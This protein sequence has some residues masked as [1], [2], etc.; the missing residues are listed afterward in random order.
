MMPPNAQNASTTAAAEITT[1]SA[2]NVY[3]PAMSDD[4]VDHSLAEVAKTF[5]WRE[6]GNG[7]ANGGA[8]ATWAD[9]SMLSGTADDIAYVMDDGLTSLSGDNAKESSTAPGNLHLNADNDFWYLTFIGTGITLKSTQYPSGGLVTTVVQNLPYGT[10]ILK[11]LRPN[12]GVPVYT[13]D[14]VTITMAS[15]QTY[16]NFNDV[17]FHQPKMPP[18]PE[19]AVVIADYML[20]ADYV[21]AS[22]GSGDK[23]SKGVR[24][25]S[26]SRDCF[27]NTSGTFGAMEVHMSTPPFG[28]HGIYTSH[29]SPVAGDAQCKLPSFGTHLE[30][31]SYDNR[32]DIFVDT[33]DMANTGTGSATASLL[34]QDV[35]STLGLHVF[36][37]RNSSSNHNISS[38][39]IASPIHTSS[40]YQTF[41]TPFLHELV[42]GDR[43]M[44]Q[45][46]LVVTP[47]GKTWDEVTRDVSYL[48]NTV[49]QSNGVIAN[50]HV[51]DGSVLIFDDWRGMFDTY[52]CAFNKDWAIA[53]D[54][55]I[56]LVDGFYEIALMS[57]SG[58]NNHGGDIAIVYHNGI[59]VSRG[60]AG[61]SGYSNSYNEYT[62]LFKRGD[63]I[64]IKGDWHSS[65]NNSNYRITRLK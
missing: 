36:E 62:T 31:T 29:G 30:I 4:A 57:I 39:R 9:A 12:S 40:H 27:H 53:Y 8:G 14:G 46:N 61:N 2:T 10:H 1:P 21:K 56:C 38:M 34:T 42:G 44:E 5:N 32:G 55:V 24:A 64:Q 41:E 63:T 13:I 15:G 37:S 18:I 65:A 19:D 20:M 11:G 58:G 51:T 7:A 49:L 25:V 3:L 43:N 33:V 17:T 52:D 22:A 48:G 54:R 26:T 16:A 59:L 50:S 60:Y 47:D 28:F 6:F 23:I 35:A 45:T